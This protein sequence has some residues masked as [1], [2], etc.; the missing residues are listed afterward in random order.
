MTRI[1]SIPELYSV[2]VWHFKAEGNA[3]IILTYNG[4]NE[5][6]SGIVI[7]LRKSNYDENDSND[8]DNENM[9]IDSTTTITRDSKDSP[10][11][12]CLYIDNVVKP[13]LGES[14]GEYVG[15]TILLKVQ[16]KFLKELSNSIRRF[17]SVKR[18]HKDIDFNQQYAILT[19]DQTQFPLINSPTLSS[20][21]LLPPP[22]S[23]PARSLSSP[24]RSS[25]STVP[26]PPISSP[27]LSIE[28]K[29][30]WLFL[31]NSPFISS[32]NSIKFQTCRFCMHKYYKQKDNKI[33]QSLITGYCPLDL[34]SFENQRMKKSI[35][36]LFK[37][38]DNNLKIFL[39]GEQ[40][41]LEK[42][43]QQ[44]LSEFFEIDAFNSPDGNQSQNKLIMDSIVKLLTET[45][46]AESSLFNHLKY[47]QR[48]LDES[49]IEGIHKLYLNQQQRKSNL[50]DPTIEEWKFVVENYKQRIRN[51]RNHNHHNNHNNNNNYQNYHHYQNHNNYHNHNN[52]QNNIRE[53]IGNMNNS[54]IQQRIY[55]FLISTT[56]KDCSI[57]F[58]FK[59]SSSSQGV[60]HDDNN[61]SKAAKIS[62][63]LHK[64][65]KNIS[66]LIPSSS[67][68]SHS[69]SLSQLHSSSSSRKTYFLKD[70]NSKKE[71]NKI[72]FN[73]ICGIIDLDPKF[74]KK[75]L[76]YHHLDLKIVKNYLKHLND[77]RNGEIRKYLGYCY[78]NGIGIIKDEAK[79]FQW[80]LKST[81]RGNTIEQYNLGHCGIGTN[82]D[83]EKTFQRF[84]S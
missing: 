14:I 63:V 53:M 18:L 46:L 30:K 7:R 21:V 79:S 64:P 32:Q 69:P 41:P 49:D 37:S 10:I 33:D 35:E 45:I 1:E 24:A 28:L 61:R 84:L 54:Q 78:E 56:F 20:S 65:F 82:K 52:N 38:P 47:L 11:F 68:Q 25:S 72:H 2:K 23:S 83:E 51:L 13:L 70:S 5:K 71:F 17:R 43:W 48:T 81:E 39:Q 26:S 57:I 76:Y 55:E 16:P 12:S 66:I 19:F 73:Y 27:T 67:S 22:P 36:E 8:E 58:T 6:F 62:P 31:P 75:I 29:P 40:V 4:E 50:S 60:V 44:Q 74:I 80:F 59:K 42:N 34:V 77:N 3:N 9:E 15:E